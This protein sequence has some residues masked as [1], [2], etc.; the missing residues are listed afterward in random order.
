MSKSSSPIDSENTPT[1][2][3]SAQ[4]FPRPLIAALIAFLLAGAVAVG[5][6]RQS[7]Q[8]H[9]HEKRGHLAALA[10]NHGDAIQNSMQRALSATYALAALV[11]Q[12]KGSIANFDAIASEM[13]RYYPGAASL[14]LAPGGIVQHIVP[15]AG[16]EKAIGHNL[17]QDHT[18]NKE[19]FLARDSGQLTLA[20]P[21]QLIQGGLGAVGRLPVPK[22]SSDTRMPASRNASSCSVIEVLVS[23]SSP[24]V[25]SSTMPCPGR[26]SSCI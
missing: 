15:L 19:A 4:Q 16:N 9:L 3:R 22:S 10:G 25:I 8:Y 7:E 18:R 26:P 23:S 6:V 1:S 17:L 21:F 12:G 24:S 13:L 20:G 2:G 11:R 14:Q 5:V